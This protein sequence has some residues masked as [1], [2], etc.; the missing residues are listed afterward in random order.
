MSVIPSPIVEL[1]GTFR[2]TPTSL[3]EGSPLDVKT[4]SFAWA[5]KDNKRG[6]WKTQSGNTALISIVG[7][8]NG[9]LSKVGAYGNL[10]KQSTSVRT[11]WF[12]CT[13]LMQRTDCHSRR[14]KACKV[15]GGR[16]PP[17]RA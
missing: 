10:Y 12:F 13:L 3:L 11:Y 6:S 14:V 1:L 4:L 2:E 17:G 16:H 5:D 8:V 9:S 15:H 7:V